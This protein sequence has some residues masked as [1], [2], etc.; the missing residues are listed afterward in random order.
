MF[1][2]LSQWLA[3]RPSPCTS[4][5]I[6]PTNI[7]ADVELPNFGAPNL[8]APDV[9]P[10]HFPFRRVAIPSYSCQRSRLS[11]SCSRDKRKCLCLT[12]YDQCVQDAY[13]AIVGDDAKRMEGQAQDKR[14]ET[15]RAANQ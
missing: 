12:L 3:P 13:G 9:A 8:P 6:V 4:L 15:K 1:V 14:G 2:I 7:A 10:R 5:I 11:V